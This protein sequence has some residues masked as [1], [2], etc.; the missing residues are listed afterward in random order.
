MSERADEN[1]M[2]RDEA[3]RRDN[4]R[5]MQWATRQKT[6]WT[7][8]EDAVILEDWVRTPAETRDEMGVAR[9]LSRSLFSCQGRAEDLRRLYGI[10]TPGTSRTAPR[11]P[12]PVCQRCF[13]ELPATGQCDNCD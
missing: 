11:A 9:R 8:E 4:E 2:L 7:P 13:I 5:S 3:R 10:S 1:R 6:H 12:A